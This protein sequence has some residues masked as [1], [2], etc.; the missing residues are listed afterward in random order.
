MKIRRK[1]L[2]GIDF[3]IV[4]ALAIGVF[5]YSELRVFTTRLAVV[6]AADDIANTML[7][8]RR[9]EKNYLASRDDGS[10]RNLAPTSGSCARAIGTDRRRDRGRDPCGAPRRDD[11]GAGRVR[12]RLRRGAGAAEDTV[13]DRR[14]DPLLEQLR[15]K[16]RDVQARA[17]ELSA[18]EREASTA[19]SRAPALAPAAVGAIAAAIVVGVASTGRLS[20]ASRP[21]PETSRT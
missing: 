7:E 9:Y 15:A 19:C 1:L 10:A 5:A 20:G 18:K 11:R 2:F 12:G 3:S 16:A 13:G 6:E 14:G 17:E 21:A 8:V 4:V